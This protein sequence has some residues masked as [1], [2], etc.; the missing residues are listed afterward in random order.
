MYL[1]LDYNIFIF[2]A[3]LSAGFVEY[4]NCTSAKG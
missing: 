1:F 3:T 4:A 2:L